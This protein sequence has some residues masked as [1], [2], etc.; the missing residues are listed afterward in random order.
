MIGGACLFGVPYLALYLIPHLTQILEVM[1]Q[2]GAGGGVAAS[3]SEHSRWYKVYAPVQEFSLPVR[4]AFGFGVPLFVLSTL[5]MCVVRPTRAVAL[6][7]LPLMLT[8]FL[9]TPHKQFSYLIHEMS[10]FLTALC[11]VVLTAGSW[12]AGRIKI[13]AVQTVSP[14]VAA[15]LLGA[16]LIGGN[17]LMAGVL[18]TF[19]P[20]IQEGEVARAAARSILGSHAKVTS[21]MGMWYAGGAAD[22]HDIQYDILAFPDSYDPVRYLANFDAAV[23]HLHSSDLAYPGGSTLSAWYAGGILKLRGFFFGETN[24]ELQY[25]LLSLDRPSRVVGYAMKKGRAYRFEEQAGGDQEL[26]LS[27]CAAV[28][29]DASKQLRRTEAPFAMLALPDQPPYRYGILIHMLAPRGSQPP[30]PWLASCKPLNAIPGTL[31]PA[32]KDA[33][34]AALRREDQPIRFAY[35]LEDL[36]GYH[37]TGVPAKIA[38]PTDG[39]RLE[40]V[41]EPAKLIADVKRPVGEP[42]HFL[43]TTPG[44]MGSFAAHVPVAHGEAV[45]MPCWVEL[46]LRVLH[47]RVGF[48]VSNRR[49]GQLKQA[50]AYLGQTEQPVDVA[51]SMPSLKDANLV[52]IFNAGLDRPSQVEVLDATV[53]VS[54]ETWARNQAGLAAVR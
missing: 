19:E 51:L 1:K 13:P 28:P 34:V 27:V 53:V 36:P 4:T 45:D 18:G 33:M 46:R 17:D 37:E 22:W 16:Y 50:A 40:H 29:K 54:R 3:V 47:G 14:A 8:V 39:V 49:V 24:P 20:T 30:L 43:V 11:L 41:L 25:V 5:A 10:F 9:V 23:D 44:G 52:T 2:A 35:G 38:A 7:A 32:D 48:L 12:L 31:A 15:V 42:P 6:A 21:R 26:T